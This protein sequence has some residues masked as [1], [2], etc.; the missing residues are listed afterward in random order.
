MVNPP[1]VV[2]AAL[3]SDVPLMLVS[4]PT[5]GQPT[6]G[7]TLSQAMAMLSG[8]GAA[9]GDKVVRVPT[10]INS[11][12]DIINGGLHLPDGVEQELFVVAAE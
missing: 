6:Q 5:E 1:P 10:S 11:M 2:T 4:A 3:G 12:E 7:V 8:G 9:G